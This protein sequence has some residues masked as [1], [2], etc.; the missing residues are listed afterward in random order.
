[1]WVSNEGDHVMVDAS[2]CVLSFNHPADLRRYAGLNNYRLESE[3]PILHDLDSVAAWVAT[4]S[5]AVDC[6]K[7]LAA[8]NLFGDVADS[9]VDKGRA[10][11]D[12]DSQLRAIYDKLFRG[13]NLPSVTPKGTLY[14][15]EWSWDET[16]ALAEILAVGL[17]LFALCTRNWHEAA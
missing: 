14:I 1:M 5:L 13:N 15:P 6:N 2:G 7:T 4:P 11:R 8:W 10:F 3:E 12:L 17:N 16:A 9:I